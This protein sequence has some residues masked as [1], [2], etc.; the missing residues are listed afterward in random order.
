[1]LCVVESRVAVRH[2]TKKIPS[3]K[4]RTVS[5]L[6]VYRRC[7]R[8][9][10]AASVAAHELVDATSG[11]DE[12]A[13][14]SIEGVRGAGDFELYYGV[15]LAFEDDGVSGLASAAA[16]EHVAIAH[17]LEYNGTIVFGMDTLFH[18]VVKVFVRLLIIKELLT[19]HA[20]NLPSE[21]GVFPCGMARSACL[22]VQ[23][24]GCLNRVQIY[25]FILSWQGCKRTFFR[26]KHIFMY[27]CIIE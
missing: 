22:L 23:T 1:M 16:E 7:A 11:V 8:L 5:S 6:S 14:T 13:L 19:Q 15:F 24:D 21:H 4:R 18:G 26:R 20:G 25:D 12:L 10:A 17:I 3:F 27:F 9:L 2:G